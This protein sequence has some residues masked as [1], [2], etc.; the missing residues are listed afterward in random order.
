VADNGVLAV[1]V[2]GMWVEVRDDLLFPFFYF[3]IGQT[4]EPL[5]M[6][7]HIETSQ[8]LQAAFT[9]D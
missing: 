7:A 4:S 6:S 3:L 1:G 9:L 5:S 8:P 2:T